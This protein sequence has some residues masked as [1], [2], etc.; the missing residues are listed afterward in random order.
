MRQVIYAIFI[1]NNRPWFH[2]WLKENLVK[3][4]KI[5]KYYENDCLQSFV[6][7]FLSLLATPIVENS[8]I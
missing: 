4:Q 5:S 1:S 7:L 2:L 3:H 8:H 6:L